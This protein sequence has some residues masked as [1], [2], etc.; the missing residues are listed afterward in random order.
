MTWIQSLEVFSD[1]LA[2]EH[3]GPQPVQRLVESHL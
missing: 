1:N 3:A 2:R